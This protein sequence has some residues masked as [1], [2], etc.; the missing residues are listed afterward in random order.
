MNANLKRE[1]D[2][3]EKMVNERD[4]KI[5]ILQKSFN[6]Q[7]THLTT[8]QAKHNSQLV[9]HRQICAKHKL[10]CDSLKQE[11]DLALVQLGILQEEREKDQDDPIAFALSPIKVHNISPV[12]LNNAKG[13]ANGNTNATTNANASSPTATSPKNL[14]TR[15]SPTKK[16]PPSSSSPASPVPVVDTSHAIKLQSRLYH[17]MKSLASLQEQ[18]K[19]MKYNYDDVVD[20][21]EQDLLDLG[22]EKSNVEVDLMTPVST[23]EREK[24]VMEG[25][26]KDQVRNRDLKIKRLERKVQSS[27]RG[28]TDDESLGDDD[29][30]EE[31]EEEEYDGDVDIDGE[32][33][34][35]SQGSSGK[36]GRA[37]APIPTTTPITTNMKKRPSLVKPTATA[38][39]T[40]TTPPPPQDTETVDTTTSMDAIDDRESQGS[41]TL[42]SGNPVGRDKVV[43]SLLEDLEIVTIDSRGSKESSTLGG[44]SESPSRRRREKYGSS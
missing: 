1:R 29:E 35:K 38:T 3:L 30:N 7:Q 33:V 4:E 2:L 43:E 11:R 12:K 16:S 41:S 18:A 8:L 17:A 37:A 13:D 31:E 6:L 5:T 40:T 14:F 42:A 19:A 39:T 34:K 26:Y 23:L 20:S 27:L 10:A 44:G 24:D 36:S 25:L 22:E 28:V 9:R 21:L 32:E 15:M